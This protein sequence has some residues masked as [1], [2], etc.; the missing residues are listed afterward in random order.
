MVKKTKHELPQ[1]ELGFM[2]QG[3]KYAMGRLAEM[4]EMGERRHRPHHFPTSS[5]YEI[6]DEEEDQPVGNGIVSF[7]VAIAD[8]SPVM[9]VISPQDLSHKYVMG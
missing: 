9:G 5:L 8:S 1:T 6:F 7:S 3:E 4:I 2:E